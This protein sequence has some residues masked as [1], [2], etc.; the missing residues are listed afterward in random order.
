MAWNAGVRK[1]EVRV[2][3]SVVIALIATHEEPTHQHAGEILTLR[4][5]ISRD[6][7]VIFRHTYR[8]GNKAA[9]YLVEIGHTL[10]LGIHIIPIS[11]CNLRYYLCLDCMSISE[12]RFLPV[13]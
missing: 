1:V 9:D 7:E 3:S 10:P 5:L 8:V 4:Q 11:N 2:D 13:N 12:L 6:W